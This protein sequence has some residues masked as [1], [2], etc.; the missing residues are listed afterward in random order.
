MVGTSSYQNYANSA[1]LLLYS[2]IPILPLFIYPTILCK[3]FRLAKKIRKSVDHRCIFICI[4]F[5]F[6]FL[7]NEYCG[8][9]EWLDISFKKRKLIDSFALFDCCF[10]VFSFVFYKAP[11]QMIN[12]G[13]DKSLGHVCL[14]A[15]SDYWRKLKFEI[16]R[17]RGMHKGKWRRGGGGGGK[18]NEFKPGA[19]SLE[20][21]RER[22][23]GGRYCCLCPFL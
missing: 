9:P 3:F 23:Q 10:L 20:S 15:V 2:R 11:W 17:L 4:Y 13:L 19:W 16:C 8:W 14:A 1:F 18:R 5:F 7:K 21:E 12:K 22:M 6:K